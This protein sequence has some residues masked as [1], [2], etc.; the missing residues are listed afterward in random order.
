MCAPEQRNRKHGP[1][2]LRRVYSSHD[3]GAAGWMI[4]VKVA[5]SNSRDVSPFNR[6]SISSV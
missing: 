4:Q 3:G 1:E 5:A 6:K 2:A